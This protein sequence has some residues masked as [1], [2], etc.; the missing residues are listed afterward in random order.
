MYTDVYEMKNKMKKKK[1]VLNSRH[2]N[3]LLDKLKININYYQVCD[4]KNIQ[5]RCIYRAVNKLKKKSK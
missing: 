5:G 4:S 2:N 3:Y 1:N